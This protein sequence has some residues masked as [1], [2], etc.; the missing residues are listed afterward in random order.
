MVS[1]YTAFYIIH[2]LIYFGGLRRGYLHCACWKKHHT[3]TFFYVKMMYWILWSHYLYL[4]PFQGI[5]YC[6]PEDITQF[7]IINKVSHD[8]ML[9]SPSFST[10]RLNT[11]WQH[12]NPKSTDHWNSQF[13]NN[14][15][16]LHAIYH[17]R[18]LFVLAARSIL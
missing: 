7:S 14:S 11:V 13:R 10:L 18:Y 8:I 3:H 17:K 12:T 16:H 6:Y 1:Y 5:S 2:S 15:K 9:H 4:I